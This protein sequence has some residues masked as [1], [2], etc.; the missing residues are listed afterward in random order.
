MEDCI[1]LEDIKKLYEEMENRPSGDSWFTKFDGSRITI[2]T[3][4]SF[5]GIELFIEELEHKIEVIK[6][7]K[8]TKTYK[9]FVAWKYDK[10]HGCSEVTRN[11]KIQCFEDIKGIVKYL[12][13]E[14]DLKGIVILNFIEWKGDEE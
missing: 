13:K 4:Y 3:G 14:N 7:E 5:E 11:E 10:G 1:S 12:E 2:D 8:D 6:K 9:Y